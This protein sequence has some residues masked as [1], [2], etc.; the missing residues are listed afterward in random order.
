MYHDSFVRVLKMIYMVHSNCLQSTVNFQFLFVVW[1]LHLHIRV[2]CLRFYAKFESVLQKCSLKIHKV[3]SHIMVSLFFLFDLPLPQLHHIPLFFRN[4]LPPHKPNSSVLMSNTGISHENW[5]QPHPLN[6]S[7]S[8]SLHQWFQVSLNL[9]SPEF[10]RASTLW[11]DMGSHNEPYRK[12]CSSQLYKSLYNLNQKGI[13]YTP[14]TYHC[15]MTN[16]N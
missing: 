11:P 1:C 4:H 2:M 10:L 14:S 15:C 13:I 8:F 9:L 6:W 16:W 3:L 7:L 12:N 5:C